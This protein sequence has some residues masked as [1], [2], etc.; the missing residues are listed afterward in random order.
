MRPL[1]T[2]R[3]NELAYPYNEK[4]YSGEEAREA[5]STAYDAK[6]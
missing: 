6:P 3:L 1:I 2:Q 5:V 4:R